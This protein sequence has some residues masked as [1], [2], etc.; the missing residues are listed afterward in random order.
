MVSGLDLHQLDFYEHEHF[1]LVFFYPWLL[2]A[3]ARRNI[4]YIH[5]A[6]DRDKCG[7]G[8]KN[9]LENSEKQIN[10]RLKMDNIA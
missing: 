3:R 6:Y 4:S 1:G 2:T 5:Q 9:N 8:Y 10:F 7:P